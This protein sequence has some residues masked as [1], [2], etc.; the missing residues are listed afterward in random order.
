M[1]WKWVREGDDEDD[2]LPAYV[3]WIRDATRAAVSHI[4][5]GHVTDLVQ[6]QGKRYWTWSGHCARRADRR[7]TLLTM[8][9]QV[10]GARAQGHPVKRWT[11][12]INSCLRKTIGRSLDEHEWI[13]LA[14]DR[15]WW[16]SLRADFAESK[17]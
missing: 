8:T 1:G 15:G 6:E 2:G 13:D 10:D 7:W 17:V 4:D 12:S 9:M 5:A 14:Q 3:E 16:N 11:D